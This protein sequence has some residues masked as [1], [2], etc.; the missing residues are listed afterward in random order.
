M[1]PDL[2]KAHRNNDKA[3]LQAYGLPI[4]ATE[5]EILTHLFKMY[6]KL[7]DQSK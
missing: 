2:R 7:T 1:P 3:V 6:E 4:D 5:S